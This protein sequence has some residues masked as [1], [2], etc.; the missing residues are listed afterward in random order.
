MKAKRTHG[1]AR[2]G[3]GR[4]KQKPSTDVV[5][6]H[7]AETVRQHIVEKNSDLMLSTQAEVVKHCNGDVKLA[8]QLINAGFVPESYH[9]TMDAAQRVINRAEALT[10]LPCYNP[11]KLLSAKSVEPVHDAD[12]LCDYSDPLEE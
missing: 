9:E 11:R 6:Y 7:E 8:M 10:A 4:R 5:V 2:K 3:A 12:G 1:G